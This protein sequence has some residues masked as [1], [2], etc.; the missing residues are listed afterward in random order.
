MYEM[1]TFSGENN[2]AWETGNELAAIR[3]ADGPAP[4]AWTEEIAALIK[5]LAPFHLVSE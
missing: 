2:I 5:S 1:I 3:F 4:P